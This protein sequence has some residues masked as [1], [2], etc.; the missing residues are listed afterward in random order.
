MIQ[1]Q[2]LS[3][4][5][6]WYF[7]QV[8]SLYYLLPFLSVAFSM[9]IF[10]LVAHWNKNNTCPLIFLSLRSVLTVIYKAP[11]LWNVY[12]R[13]YFWSAASIW[14]DSPDCSHITVFWFT[15]WSGL[16][17]HEPGSF[18]KKFTER[19]DLGLYFMCSLC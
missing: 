8:L 2:M 19:C 14:S 13:F 9:S 1:R 10:G 12:H 18:K 6:F 15:S 11:L 17:V 5:L 7:K 16:I 4:G 3:T